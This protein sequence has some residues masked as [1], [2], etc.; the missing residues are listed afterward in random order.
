MS[1]LYILEINRL[2]V[3]SFATIFS[4]SEGCLFILFIVSFAVQKLLSFMSFHFLIFVFLSIN[5]AGRSEFES[6][7]VRWMN[8]DSYTDLRMSEREKQ[9]SYME[10]R[11]MVPMNL[12]DNR[13][14]DIEAKGE[15]GMN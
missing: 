11:K 3:A 5:L 6:D 14:R 1:C 13:F 15:G 8:L 7:V 12:V 10:S 2:S 9:I 4:H